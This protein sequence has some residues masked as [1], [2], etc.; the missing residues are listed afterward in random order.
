M[1]WPRI[2][3]IA[4]VLVFIPI[5]LVPV[6]SN[7]LRSETETVSPC[8]NGVAVPTDVEAG[9]DLVADC[10]VLLQVRDTLAGSATLNWSADRTITDWEGISFFFSPL[11][12]TS[13]NLSERD[14]TGTIPPQFSSLANLRSLYLGDNQLSGPIPPEIGALTRLESLGLSNNQLIGPI[15][16]GLANLAN[17]RHLDLS[18]NQL[19]GPIPPQLGALTS[20]WLLDLSDNQLASPIPPELAALTELDYVY[21]RGNSLTGCLPPAFRWVPKNDLNE[22][23]LPF[24]QS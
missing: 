8:A 2:V 19:T 15:P 20:L 5:P 12:L 3:G 16:V 11:R 21:L 23:G 7:S 4:V 14:L 17:L 13:I 6:L 24:C 10:T 18:D 9:P 22:L 1:R